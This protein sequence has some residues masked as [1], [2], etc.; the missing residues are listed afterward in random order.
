MLSRHGNAGQE[1]VRGQLPIRHEDLRQ[2]P[3]V[4]NDPDAALFGAKGLRGQDIVALVKRLPD[5]TLL[6]VEEVLSG[7]RRL[8]LLSA[9]RFPAAIDVSRVAA[10]LN[11]YARST[12]QGAVDIV[13]RPAGG[14]E[15]VVYKDGEMSRRWE[16]ET[17][18]L[19]ERP[20]VDRK[21]I[22]SINP[23]NKPERQN[24]HRERRDVS[25]RV[26]AP[27]LSTTP[28]RPLW[29]RLPTPTRPWWSD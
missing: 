3:T 11:L 10:T 12:P 23:K 4:V 8:A 28:T 19:R 27:L 14:K 13:E 9:R 29:K 24:I 21:P 5:G 26:S 15:R 7:R 20:T 16:N 18:P 25:G 17:P 6:Y 1:L 2:I 22:L